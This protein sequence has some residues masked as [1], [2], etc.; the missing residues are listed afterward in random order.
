[1]R[2]AIIGWGSLIW[3]T[4]DL[5]ITKEGWQEEG[6]VLPIE[7]SRISRKRKGALTLV[8]DPKNGENKQTQFAVSSRTEV[9]EAID[10]L[11]ERE[12][13]I[14]ERPI[15]FVRL[16]DGKCRCN[17]SEKVREIVREWAKQHGFDAVIWTDLPPKFKH[18]GK[19]FSV[20]NAME[21]LH[22]LKGER[23]EEAQKYIREAPKKVNTRL[24]RR[25]E[26]EEWLEQ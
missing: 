16:V 13:C 7:F 23:K 8:I 11:R 9:D 6:P 5:P 4:R 1:M 15:G 2:I 10:D 24:R 14:T 12:G 25:V 21:Y 20:E 18:D 19:G 26:E 22:T 3:D 17:T